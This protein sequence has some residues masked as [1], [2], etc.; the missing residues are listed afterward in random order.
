MVP[1]RTTAGR[2]KVRIAKDK[3][4]IDAPRAKFQPLWRK[5]TDVPSK[6]FPNR[7]TF[8]IPGIDPVI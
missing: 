5:Y 6:E 7:R 4:R 8:V 1:A 2:Q 3:R